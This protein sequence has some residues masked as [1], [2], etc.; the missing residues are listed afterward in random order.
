MT[1]PHSR[2][3]IAADLPGL[4][5]VCQLTGVSATEAADGRN[6]DLLGHVYAG[7]YAAAELAPGREG[8]A[9]LRLSRAVV[10]AEGVCGYLLATPDTRDFEAWA[11]RAWWP[12][13]REQYPLA[14]ATGAHPGDRELIRTLHQPPRSPDAVADAF[15][16]HLHIDLL[17]RARGIGLG[18]TLIRDL[19]ARLGASGIPGVHLGVGADNTNAIGFY[20]HLGF[21]EVARS[22]DVVWM[23]RSTS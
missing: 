6:P 19:V 12:M 20:H 11:E 3:L 4:Y 21:Q 7:P 5:R 10:D 9:E 22:P 18:G 15:P 16:A 1:A 2:G 13:L 17:D 14:A 8:L 23:A